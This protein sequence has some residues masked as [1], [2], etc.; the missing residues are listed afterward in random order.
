MMSPMSAALF[1][2]PNISTF[3]LVIFDEASQV[4][5]EDAVGSLVRAKQAVVVGDPKQLPPTNFFQM[6]V[7]Q[8][9]EQTNEEDDILDDVDSVLDEF[10]SIGFPKQSL[11]WHYRSQ[12][13]SLI[14]FSNR[15]FY[16]NL[17]TFPAPHNGNDELGLQF[18]FI[19]GNYKGQGVNPIEARAVA[20]AV[21]E[22]IKK[23]PN[24]SLGVGTF[25][26]NQQQLILDELE[27]RR[28]NDAS[29]EFFFAKKGE[30]QFFVKNLENI[31]GD[32]RDV[33]IISVTYGPDEFGRI[34][35]NF[36]PVNGENGWR[37]SM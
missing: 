12:H 10:V 34:R 1:L 21:C 27:Q 30:D 2:D 25:N 3:D 24:L 9:D 14:E 36:G 13:E 7:S 15:H 11:L 37:R 28:R 35:Y 20:D 17:L 8:A 33:I 29:L 23:Y 31:Q 4:S 6:Q 22:H 18:N 5:T 19:K 32:E 16:K 26:M